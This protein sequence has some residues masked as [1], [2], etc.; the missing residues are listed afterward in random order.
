MQDDLT[1]LLEFSLIKFPSVTHDFP[2]IV[3]HHTAESL[4]LLIK[5]TELEV[6]LTHFPR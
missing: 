2:H 6:I 1:A 3:R 5:V 4:T